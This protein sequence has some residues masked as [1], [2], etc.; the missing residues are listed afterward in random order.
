MIDRTLGSYEFIL[1][2]DHAIIK[3]DGEQILRINQYFETI[4]QCLDE[5]FKLIKSKNNKKGN[6]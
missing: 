5:L 6:K 3:K 4:D 1:Y 2:S